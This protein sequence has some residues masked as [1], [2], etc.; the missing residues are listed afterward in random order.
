MV[1]GRLALPTASNRACRR[2]NDSHRPPC[3]PA[4]TDLRLSGLAHQLR[5]PLN[6]IIGFSDVLLDGGGGRI[7]PEQRNQ[8]G[9]INRSG[10]L[11]LQHVDRLLDLWRLEAGELHF[12]L[13]RT[14]LREALRRPLARFAREARAL[15]LGCRVELD[16]GLWL[17]TD[18]A[19]A[20]QAL[21][22][23]L[24]C[25][26]QHTASGSIAVRALRRDGWARVSVEGGGPGLPP[27]EP[28]RLAGGCAGSEA[29]GAGCRYD[30][31]V[32][33]LALARGLVQ[34]LGGR[35]GVGTG[36]GRG[37]LWFELPLE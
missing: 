10:L 8:L 9:M 32:L 18:P 33:G 26:L 14:D 35:I 11:L 4:T 5:T 3:P 22:Q 17:R 25:A 20:A 13:R 21:E 23:L 29:A 19:R 30:G 28:G 1:R 34:A 6:S 24:A 37:R 27:R 12:D 36:P 16:A 2:L 31:D 7:T 15:G